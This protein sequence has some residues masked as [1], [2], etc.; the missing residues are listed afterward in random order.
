MATPATLCPATPGNWR[1][2]RGCLFSSIWV[3]EKPTKAANTSDTVWPLRAANTP[4][5]ANAPPSAMPGAS[6]LTMSQRTVPRWWCA[7]RL[8][9][10]VNAI[11]AMQV[12][13]ATLTPA[14]VPTPRWARIMV[15]KGVIIMPPPMPNRPAMKPAHRPRAASSAISCGSNMGWRTGWRE[16]VRCEKSVCGNHRTGHPKP[17]FRW[18]RSAPHRVHLTRDD[19]ARGAMF[20]ALAQ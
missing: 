2:A 14:S 7:R 12:A 18:A 3:A 16:R 6:A 4:A 13:M 10:L 20:Q 9:R 19:R 17:Q 11:M 8:D 1:L 5:L 15:I